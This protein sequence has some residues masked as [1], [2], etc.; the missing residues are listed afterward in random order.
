MRHSIFIRQS[1]LS[2]SLIVPSLFVS[3]QA[4]EVLWKQTDEG[5]ILDARKKASTPTRI[6]IL[7]PVEVLI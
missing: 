7:C 1:L 6:T 4:E 2:L 3:T 5:I